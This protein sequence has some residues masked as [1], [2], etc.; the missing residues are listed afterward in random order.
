MAIPWNRG[1]FR[2]EMLPVCRAPWEDVP[3]SAELPAC[4]C[5]KPR[6]RSCDQAIFVDQ[7]T[8]A[9]VS[10]D[11]V[12]VEIDRV[13]QRLQR[14]GAVQ[15]AVRP[16]LVMVSLVLAQDP[17]QMSLVPHQGAVRELAAASPDPA[18][19]DPVHAGRPHVAPHGPDPGAGEDRVERGGEARA[20]VADHERDSLRLLAEVHEQVAGLLRG[21]FPG[22]VQGDSEDADAPGRVL[23]HGQAW[24]RSSNSAV[25]KSQARIASAWERRNC[26][27]AGPVRRS[28]GPVPAFLRIS[29]TVDAETR[30][31]RPAS[32][33][34]IL[35]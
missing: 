19:G 10:S 7:A 4:A 12:L 30:T 35:R 5:R 23:D 24:V 31:P 22:G 26:D 20:A 9:S 8:D 18:F 29:H 13:G 33:P 32:S 28:A 21:P 2:L 27:Q 11:A 16:M 14:R 34:W 3:S 6:P 15:G 1:D 17:P 25:K